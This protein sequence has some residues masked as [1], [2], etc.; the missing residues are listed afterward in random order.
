MGNTKP[1]KIKERTAQPQLVEPDLVDRIFEYI[2]ADFP[3]MSDRVALLRDTV[4]QEFAGI[5]TYIARKSPTAK[6]IQVREVLRLFD[7]RNAREIARRLQ[8]SRASV[9]RII[10]TWGR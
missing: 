8:I 10:K 1:S 5:E 2:L 9:Y 7:G 3:H 6:Q 4:R